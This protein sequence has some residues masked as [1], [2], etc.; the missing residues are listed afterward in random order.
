MQQFPRFAQ[1]LIAMVIKK[2]AV[3]RHSSQFPRLS[4]VKADY[5]TFVKNQ[6]LKARLQAFRNSL[7]AANPRRG[8]RE[9]SSHRRRDSRRAQRH[10]LSRQVG[11]MRRRGPVQGS[12]ANSSSGAGSTRTVAAPLEAAWDS[13]RTGLRRDLGAR[14]FDGWLKPAELGAFDADSGRARHRHAEPVHGRLGALA[15]RR[16]AGAGV[17]DGRCRSS[18]KSGSSPPPMRRGRRRC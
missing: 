14:T 11:M 10:F 9:K 6:R 2:M 16:P 13:I 7:P 12:R 18:A 1:S 4:A 5:F 15:F 8:A 17:E 3:F